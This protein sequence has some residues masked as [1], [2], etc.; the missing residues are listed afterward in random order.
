MGTFAHAHSAGSLDRK[1]FTVPQPLH[2]NTI[3]A[4][5]DSRSLS[6]FLHVR[7]PQ[8]TPCPAAPPPCVSL[9]FF[10]GIRASCSLKRIHPM[11]TGM[12]L[13][14]VAISALIPAAPAIAVHPAA[15]GLLRRGHAAAAIDRTEAGLRSPAF[16]ARAA[17]AASARRGLNLMMAEGMGARARA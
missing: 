10:V 13:A 4:L 8:Q 6:L 9:P 3:A 15:A 14:A 12:L 2:A 17:S 5:S 16:P 1:L 11:V 7:P